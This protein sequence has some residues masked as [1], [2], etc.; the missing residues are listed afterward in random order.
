MAINAIPDGYHSV[1]PM[2]VVEGAGRLIDFL[3]QA[4]GAEQRFLMPMP[5][6]SIGHAELTIGDSVVMVSDATPEWPAVSCSVHLYVQDVDTT[7]K[8]AIEAGATSKMEPEDRFY[9]DRAAAVQDPLG[10]LWSL[11]THIEDVSDE[12]MERRMAAMGSA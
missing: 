11:A 5:D 10:N 2:L 1:T 6:G 4:F 7:H 12:E 8:R 3:K 9:G